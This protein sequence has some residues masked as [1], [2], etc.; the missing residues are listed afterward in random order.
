[1]TIAVDGTV[2]SYPGAREGDGGA[3]ARTTG[4]RV[5]KDTP[6]GLARYCPDGENAEW[7]LVMFRAMC[8]IQIFMKKSYPE[9]KN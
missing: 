3:V 1:M 5:E 9:I 7:F 4:L 8:Y 2:V 6:C